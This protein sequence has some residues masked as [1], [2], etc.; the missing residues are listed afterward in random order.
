MSHR[1]DRSGKCDGRDPDAADCPATPAAKLMTHAEEQSL[2]QDAKNVLYH[3]VSQFTLEPNQVNGTML[4]VFANIY[5]D[6]W[7]RGRRRVM[8]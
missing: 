6:A 1:N 5:R 8:D 2:E 4:K 3:A 7:M